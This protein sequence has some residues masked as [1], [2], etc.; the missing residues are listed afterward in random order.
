MVVLVLV[1]V[2]WEVL[3]AKLCMLPLWQVPFLSPFHILDQYGLESP[4]NH[5]S[6]TKWLFCG[7]WHACVLSHRSVG[8]VNKT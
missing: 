2:A 1:D 4:P 3:V 5:E 6:V 8:S 7:F